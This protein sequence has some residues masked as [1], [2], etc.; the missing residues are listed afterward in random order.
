[1]RLRKRLAA[2]AAVTAVV[3]MLAVAARLLFKASHELLDL[4]RELGEKI[5]TLER[6][7]AANPFP[8]K[9][10]VALERRNRDV[11]SGWFKA[12]T[13]ELMRSKLT[14]EERTPPQFMRQLG[15]TQDGLRN[16]ARQ[17]GVA[18]PEGFTFGF[19][20]YAGGRDLPRPEEVPALTWQ[21]TC[22]DSLVRTLLANGV[23]DVSEV[24]RDPVESDAAV[25]PVEAS[26]L[27]LHTAAAAAVAAPARKGFEEHKL[28]TRMRF[29]L[30]FRT[31]EE[32]LWR[33]LNELVVHEPFTVVRSLRLQK[34]NADVTIPPR[35]E[36]LASAV[37]AD[38]DAAMELL[39]RKAPKHAE[40]LTCGKAVEVPVLVQLEMD[41]FVF[42][43][44]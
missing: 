27:R 23:K 16:L 30:Q 26:S 6:F 3:V 35:P 4:Q 44:G 33:I 12:L 2:V 11:L 9:D 17:K 42:R 10:N 40:R 24:T 29:G 21:L 22:I 5:A 1:M 31:R 37:A 41:V 8:S 25:R 38:R 28:Y 18:L 15:Q 20:R 32:P 13:A 34:E 7:Y 14:R 36:E 43:E 39:H 19:D